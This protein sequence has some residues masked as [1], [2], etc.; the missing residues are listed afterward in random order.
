MGMINY[1][2]KQQIFHLNNNKISYVI[3][4]S[5]TGKLMHHYYGSF[6]GNQQDF[7]WFVQ[8]S[9]RALAATQSGQS[10]SDE[11]IRHEYG[12]WGTGDYR[13]PSYSIFYGNDRRRCQ[14]AYHDHRIISSKNSILPLPEVRDPRGESETLEIVLFD[15]NAGVMLT[16][17]Y[18]IYPELPVIVRSARVLSHNEE[19]LDIKRL[20]S[21]SIDLFSEDYEAY[22][23]WGTWARERHIQKNQLSKGIFSIGSTRGASSADAN[24]F[25]ALASLHATEQSGTVYG[26][27]LI[28]SG[29]FKAQAEVDHDG[30][31]RMSIGL[32]PDNFSWSLSKDESFQTPEAVLV[33]SDTGLGGLSQGFH[34]LAKEY[35]QSPT[36][37]DTERPIVLNNWEATYFDFDEEKI[38]ELAASAKDLGAELFVL[39]DGWFGRR[40]DD[41]SSLGDWYVNT[42]KLPSGISGLSKRVTDLGIG[43][44][45]WIEPEMVNRDSDLYRSHPEWVLGDPERATIEVRNQLVLDFANPSV[46]D[47]IY[48]QLIDVIDGSAISYIKWDMNRNMT[49]PYSRYI[50]S[51]RQ[52]EVPH[53]YILG[54]YDLYR[55]LNERYPHILFESCASGGNRFDL[56]M[57]YFAPQAWTSDDTDAVERIKIQYG[58]SMVYPLSCISNHVS[59]IPN[60]QVGRSCPLK[61]RGDVACFGIFGYEM[62]P[63]KADEQLRAEIQEQVTAY[64]AFRP[65]MM[66]GHF[67]RLLSPFEGTGNQAAWMVVSKDKREALAAFYQILA[68]PNPGERRI[69]FTGLDPH[70]TYEVTCDGE[71]SILATGR[72]LLSFGYILPPVFTGH[73]GCS[74]KAEDF[75]SRLIKI[76]AV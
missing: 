1:N 65:L 76:M 37:K 49:E 16:L 9:P 48:S 58:T 25:I 36:W 2:K 19:P 33:Y 21:A 24:P 56:G 51:S 70:L 55:R 39:D 52:G 8:V 17:V 11:Y 10:I 12:T 46:V 13:E 22:S 59:D 62:D 73:G 3:G 50:G 41:T 69:R 64:K 61:F 15:S 18:T 6:I 53:R 47:A 20:N 28:Y 45:L 32:H 27:S 44:G 60:H 7:S 71:R 5:D 4:V 23:L 57:L 40:N 63:T 38:V 34:E 72:L 43:F 26:M 75:Y 29:N 14:F 42:E 74:G 68:E 35:I 30:M 31:T 54:V 66:N 67:Y